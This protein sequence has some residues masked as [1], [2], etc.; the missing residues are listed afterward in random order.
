MNMTAGCRVEA[1]AKSARTIFSPSP[2]HLDV[3][4]EAEIL[5]KVAPA[6]HAMALPIIVL[7][8]PGGPNINRPFG[9]D[10]SPVNN[11]GFLIGRMI[12]S[13]THFLA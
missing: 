6:E 8:V 1:T 11:S 10:R 12:N 7:P 3:S 9:S 4:E 2:I 13:F 5:K